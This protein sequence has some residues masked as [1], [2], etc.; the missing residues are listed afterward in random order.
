MLA[1]VSFEH[2]DRRNHGPVFGRN[3]ALHVSLSSYSLVKEPIS[4]PRRNDIMPLAQIRHG[5]DLGCSPSEKCTFVRFPWMLQERAIWSPAARRP[6]CGGYIGPGPRDCQHR[7]NEFV[8]F[9]CR[10]SF[11]PAFLPVAPHDDA[12]LRSH[13]SPKQVTNRQGAPAAVA[14]FARRG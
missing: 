6:R 5:D 2:L 3:S 12:L 13:F 14:R 8:N 11:Q 9:L 10:P 7:K 4:N 1:E